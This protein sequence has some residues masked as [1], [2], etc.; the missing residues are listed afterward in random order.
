MLRLTENTLI[1]SEFPAHL[2]HTQP[3]PTFTC[4]KNGSLTPFS[5]RFVSFVSSLSAT[6]A[7]CEPTTA[8]SANDA[9]SLTD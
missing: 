6:L 9:L 8:S 3:L 7:G 5:L 2:R 1:S 4:L